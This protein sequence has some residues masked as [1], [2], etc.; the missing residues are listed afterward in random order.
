MCVC[1]RLFNCVPSAGCSQWVCLEY[2]VLLEVTPYVNSSIFIYFLKDR[3]LQKRITESEMVNIRNAVSI[4]QIAFL[5]DWNSLYFH[6]QNCLRGYLHFLVS[7]FYF[8]SSRYWTQD[9]HTEPIFSPFDFWDRILLSHLVAQAEFKLQILW[10]QPFKGWG[11][12]ACKKACSLLF[13]CFWDRILFCNPD[14]PWTHCVTQS[15]LKLARMLLPRPSSAGITNMH[16]HAQLICF[17]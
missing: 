9:L 15:G 14:C 2:V 7:F 11:S 4:L 13:I 17:L 1:H 8:S 3:L 12:Q 16:C 6:K 10:P 5:K